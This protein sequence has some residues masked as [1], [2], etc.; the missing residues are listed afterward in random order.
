MA[1][2]DVANVICDPTRLQVCN[3]YGPRVGRMSRARRQELLL[4]NYFF[5]CNCVGCNSSHW[6]RVEREMS[7]VKCAACDG[8]GAGACVHAHDAARVA[9][10]ALAAKTCELLLVGVSGT[11]TVEQALIAVHRCEEA[12]HERNHALD[13]LRA[14]AVDFL[15]KH[16][17]PA[18]ALHFA[19]RH[20]ATVV[21]PLMAGLPRHCAA[22]RDRPIN[23]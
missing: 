12:L 8:A 4:E 5:E 9:E 11:P 22:M 14:R 7:A 18:A 3:C 13:R 16:R 17:Q 10:A 23:S 2:A 19:E 21:H 20:L 15:L 1:K 6:Q